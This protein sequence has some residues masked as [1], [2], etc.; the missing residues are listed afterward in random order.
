MNSLEK[1]I[2][3]LKKQILEQEE[4]LRTEKMMKN[5]L[6][7][8]FSKMLKADN[9]YSNKPQSNLT[10]QNDLINISENIN[11]QNPE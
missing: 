9:P 6:I 8:K 7:R 5:L 2:Q 11:Q 4:Y 1:R 10:N 3:I